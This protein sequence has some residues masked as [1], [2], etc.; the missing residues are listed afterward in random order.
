[1]AR[2]TSVIITNQ[3]HIAISS[4]L[5]RSDHL[6]SSNGF[7][8][9]EAMISVR[10]VHLHS[11]VYFPSHTGIARVHENNRGK[12]CRNFQHNMLAQK[13]LTC[14]HL[15]PP[16]FPSH[17]LRSSLNLWSA[18]CWHW[19]SEKPAFRY[20]ARAPPTGTFALSLGLWGSILI[21]LIHSVH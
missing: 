2:M 17:Q 4:H 15:P 12:D 18:W 8:E 20:D 6:R 19:S 16:H 3:V 5:N 7:S 11:G 13:S 1:M 9:Y 10:G 21:E 14:D